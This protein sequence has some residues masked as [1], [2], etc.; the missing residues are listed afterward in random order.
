MEQT[1]AVCHGKTVYEELEGAFSDLIMRENELSELHLSI[2]EYEKGGEAAPEELIN[3]YSRQLDSFTSDGGNTF[4][5]RESYLIKL[6][7]PRIVGAS[8]GKAFR[9]AEDPARA[10]TA[11]AEPAGHTPARRTYEP[12]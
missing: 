5:A 10:G 3:R 9:R 7:F 8:V 1:G 2:E 6:G 11:A 12:P 4:A